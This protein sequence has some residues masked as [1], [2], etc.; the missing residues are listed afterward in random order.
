MDKNQSFLDFLKAKDINNCL[1]K[2][3]EQ[4]L[5][6]TRETKIKQQQQ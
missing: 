4:F 5:M 1:K 3:R 6:G 2:H